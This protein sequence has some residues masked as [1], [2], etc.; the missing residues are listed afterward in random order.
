MERTLIREGSLSLEFKFASQSKKDHHNGGEFIGDR[1]KGK[2][3]RGNPNLLN[4]EVV[5]R[6]GGSRR[7]AVGGQPS[8]SERT[9]I[10]P[11]LTT[12]T[13]MEPEMESKG[14]GMCSLQ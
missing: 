2:V 14:E 7:F 4:Q 10:P 12:Q 8:R 5:G 9:N 3:L 13:K 6:N 1:V 11:H